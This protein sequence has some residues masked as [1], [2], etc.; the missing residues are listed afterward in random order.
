M[1]VQEKFDF[2]RLRKN[3][4]LIDL[5]NLILK[6]T[7]CCFEFGGFVTHIFNISNSQLEL[8]YLM[9]NMLKVLLFLV[10]SSTATKNRFGSIRWDSWIPTDSGLIVAR[11]LNPPKWHDRLPWFTTFNASGFP[12]FNGST[13]EVV[14]AEIEMAAAAGIDHFAFD[15]YDPQLALSQALQNFLNSTTPAKDKVDFCMLLQAG[16]MSNNGGLSSWPKKVE[17]YKS[18]LARSDYTLVL[19]NRPLVYLFSVFENAWGN[20]WSGWATALDMLSNASLSIGRGRPY[21]VIQIWSANEGQEIFTAINRAANQTLISALSSYALTGQTDAGTP[22]PA[23]VESGVQFWDSLVSTGIDIIPCVAAGW[24]NRPR[25]ESGPLPWQ[26]YTDPSYVIGPTPSELASFVQLADSYINNH[27]DSIPTR[28]ALLSAW[29]EY[30]EGHWIS[31]V[32]PQFGGN[33]RLD[34]IASVLLQR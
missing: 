27:T 26:N 23:F 14:D 24:D 20:S 32:L 18:Y 4:R 9:A 2:W 31:A 8:F 22:W 28:V 1:S 10:T 29:N 7:S 15:V 33:A 16:W 25:N 19:G 13:Q 3:K 11:V 30:D 21:Y 5:K 34:A 17:L 12:Q 6:V